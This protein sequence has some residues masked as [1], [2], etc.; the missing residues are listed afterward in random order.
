MKGLAL[1]ETSPT[2]QESENSHETLAFRTRYILD[3]D[4]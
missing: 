4:L 1:P 2:A 3:L